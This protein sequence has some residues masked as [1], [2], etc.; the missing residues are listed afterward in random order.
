MSQGPGMTNPTLDQAN[1]FSTSRK[2]CIP[3]AGQRKQ[4]VFKHA[5]LAALWK[6]E[7]LD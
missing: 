1:N 6:M 3:T 4:M 7:K 5:E 2:R